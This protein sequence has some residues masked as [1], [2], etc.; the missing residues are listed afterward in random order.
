MSDLARLA[1]AVGD[2]AGR[3]TLGADVSAAQAA[4]DP[5]ARRAALVR[6]VGDAA[7]RETGELSLLLQTA[8]GRLLR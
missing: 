3:A 2:S 4:A 1:G 5:A 6:F 8:G 7:G